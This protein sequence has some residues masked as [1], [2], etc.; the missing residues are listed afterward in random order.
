MNQIKNRGKLKFIENLI[1]LSSNSDEIS[2]DNYNLSLKEWSLSK[3]YSTEHLEKCICGKTIK[4]VCVIE[5]KLTGN[6]CNIGTDCAEKLMYRDYGQYFNN[7]NIKTFIKAF[8]KNSECNL[9]RCLSS[10]EKDFL[11]SI[12]KYSKKSGIDYNPSTKVLNSYY[13]LANNLKTKNIDFD[14]FEDFELYD[15][16]FILSVLD[17]IKTKNTCINTEALNPILLSYL[18]HKKVITKEQY[19]RYYL[20]AYYSYFDNIKLT[21]ISNSKLLD[22]VKKEISSIS[23]TI[24]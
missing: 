11:D 5:N 13:R 14:L 1:K 2:E 24:L 19:S 17:E 10:W 7:K 18:V 8:K 6:K 12:I 23:N 21:W 4:N 9:R 3:A 15:N 20:Y 22:L 16:E